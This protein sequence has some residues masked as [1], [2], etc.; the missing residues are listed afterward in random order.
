VATLAVHGGLAY[1]GAAGGQRISAAAVLANL[2]YVQE[3][4]AVDSPV[5]IAWSLCAEIQF[6][7]FFIALA[8]GFQWLG[9]RMPR[10]A[11]ALLVFGPPAIGSLLVAAGHGPR[12]SGIYLGEWHLFFF[13][14]L[15]YWSLRNALPSLWIGLYAA[16]MLLF[17][18]GRLLGGVGAGLV[19]QCFALLGLLDSTPRLRLLSYLGSRSYS[20]CLVHVLVGVNLARLLM[21]L[22]YMTETFLVLEAFFVVALAASVVAAEVLYRSIESPTH[23]LARRISFQTLRSRGS[24]TRHNFARDRARAS[25]DELAIR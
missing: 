22:D 16:L 14:T 3:I 23:R 20:L 7:L 15:I 11:A 19:I 13:G 6:Y 17:C 24:A 4:V 25:N 12:L 9:A 10:R 8:W 2:L 18:D 1:Y 21:R 5:R